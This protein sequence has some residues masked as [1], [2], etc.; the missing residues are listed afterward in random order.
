MSNVVVNPENP[1]DF[2]KLK[3]FATSLGISAGEFITEPATQ[4]MFYVIVILVALYVLIRTFASPYDG[5]TPV[6]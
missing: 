2:Q 3:D 6:L 1:I 4:Y 5:V